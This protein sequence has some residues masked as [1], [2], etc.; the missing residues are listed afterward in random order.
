MQG[1]K[2]NV[3]GNNDLFTRHDVIPEIKKTRVELFL[4]ERQGN[5][6]LEPINRK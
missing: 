5:I 2:P 3:C 1:A 6:F 4:K